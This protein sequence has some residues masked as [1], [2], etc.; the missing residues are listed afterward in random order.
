MSRRHISLIVLAAAV[1]A[2]LYFTPQVFFIIFAG[3]LFAVFLR[4]GGNAIARLLSLP[5]G[6]G[7]AIFAMLI[8]AFFAVCFIWFAAPVADQIN[9]FTT[10][11]PQA[12]QQVR[13]LISQYPQGDRLLER[14]VPQ[15][16]S[17]KGGS[18]A[19][20][21]VTS[22]FGGLGNFLVILVIGI[23]GAANPHLYRRGVLAL[24]TPS[25]RERGAEVMDDA[26]RTLRNWLTAQLMSMAVVGILTGL[27]LRLAGIP[28]A[29]LLGLIAGLLAF[30]PIVG[31]IAS[32]VPGLLVAFPEG[33]HTVLWALGVYVGVQ[34]LES[35]VI[36][37][38]IQQKRVH[39]PAALVLVAQILFGALFGIL[40]VI[41]ATPLT[42]LSMT[43]VDHLYVRHLEEEE[44]AAPAPKAVKA[45]RQPAKRP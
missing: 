19:T 11:V 6:A 45:P 10:E 40:G 37:P 44:P 43:L 42:A 2:L 18:A 20:S 28:L 27:G 39:L 15:M 16:I 35:N 38:L 26:D 32:T 17:A 25:L 34:L 5:P 13:D 4:G 14:M 30:V 12:V 33:W 8:V 22:T 21:A 7:I 41:L 3:V 31:P 24:L 1:L 29:F 36:T 9:E 23:Y